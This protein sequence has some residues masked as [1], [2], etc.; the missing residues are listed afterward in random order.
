MQRSK[1]IVWILI[2][3]LLLLSI[4]IVY[5]FSPEIKKVLKIGNSLRSQDSSFEKI[6]DEKYIVDPDV[7][8]Y[9]GSSILNEGAQEFF[10]YTVAEGGAQKIYDTYKTFRFDR[11]SDYG[12]KK[13]LLYSE[14]KG[15]AEYTFECSENRTFAYKSKNYEFLSSGFDFLKTLAVGDA[16]FTK[17][18]NGDCTIL[19]PDCIILKRVVIK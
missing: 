4:A 19:G 3:V 13:A 10:S 9:P 17:C 16:I 5:L 14:E 18:K 1:K 6:L 7:G 2:F 11:L 15:S 8:R 12:N